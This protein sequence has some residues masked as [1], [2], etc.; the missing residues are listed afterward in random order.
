MGIIGCAQNPI[1]TN[2]LPPIFST[3]DVKVGTPA[4]Y[5][6][7]ISLFTTDSRA[8]RRFTPQFLNMS[9]GSN[10]IDFSRYR[11]VQ[12]T[13]SPQGAFCDI[14]YEF[15]FDLGATFAVASWEAQMPS[16]MTPFDYTGAFANSLPILGQWIAHDVSLDV[17]YE[18]PCFLGSSGGIHPIRFAHGDDAGGVT[19]QI[20]AT[21][22]FTWEIGDSLSAIVRMRVTVP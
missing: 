14:K 7:E 19:N 5:P 10:R 16:G 20:N 4:G 18:G 21:T 2:A 15:E 13:Y 6:R 11:L 1:T 3:N 9:L 17:Y 12:N 8:W 22:P